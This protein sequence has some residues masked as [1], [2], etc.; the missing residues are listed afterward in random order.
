V[1]RVLT[2][3]DGWQPSKLRISPYPGPL[4]ELLVIVQISPISDDA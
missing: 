1:A 2:D 3:D 4:S